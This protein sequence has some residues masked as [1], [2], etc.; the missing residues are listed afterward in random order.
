MGRSCGQRLVR[1][2]QA[3]DHPQ[4]P[5]CAPGPSWLARCS[6]HRRSHKPEAQSNSRVPASAP[7]LSSPV[8]SS[9][10]QCHRSPPATPGRSSSGKRREVVARR[11]LR[12]DCPRRTR[13]GR[14]EAGRCSALSPRL[15]S[16]WAFSPF[17]PSPAKPRAEVIRASNN[18]RGRSRRLRFASGGGGVGW[19]HKPPGG[20]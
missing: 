2:R 10:P 20:L 8:S 17:C 4:Q 7:P 6:C 19:R 1:R 14:G 11:P 3:G 12:S 16:C 15:R 9:F 5:R 18:R 13:S